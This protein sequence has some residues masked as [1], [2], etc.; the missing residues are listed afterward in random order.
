MIGG[1]FAV[2]AVLGV[3]AIAAAAI[4]RRILDSRVDQANAALLARRHD[5]D[6]ETAARLYELARQDGFGS[7]WD[8]VVE[9]P[10]P[11]GQ[12]QRRPVKPPARKLAERHRA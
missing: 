2:A 12:S 4:V 5:L 3:L 9:H 10:V 7:A 1:M 11:V 8:E 6:A